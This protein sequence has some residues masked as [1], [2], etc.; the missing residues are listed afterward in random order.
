MKKRNILLSGVS[1]L[2]FGYVCAVIGYNFYVSTENKPKSVVTIEKPNPPNVPELL[3][4]VNEERAK[5]GVPPLVLD[6]RLNQSAQMKADDMAQNNYFGHFSPETGQKNGPNK[7]RSLTGNDCWK[8]SEN[9]VEAQSAKTAIK[10]WIKS[11]GHHRAMIDP[12]LTVTG[13]GIKND[14]IVQHFC[15]KSS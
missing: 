2:V 9:L 11:A 1:I 5:A 4:L 15:A 10:A 14:L 8:I 7:A 13:F 12:D 3:R 6:E